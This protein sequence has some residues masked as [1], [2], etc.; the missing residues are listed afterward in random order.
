M[1]HM[2]V[3]FNSEMYF[4]ILFCAETSENF[5]GEFPFIVLQ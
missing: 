3:L 2:V 4:K 5:N 1:M